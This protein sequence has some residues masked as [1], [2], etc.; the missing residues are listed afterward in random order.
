MSNHYRGLIFD[1]DGVIVDSEALHNDAVAAAVRAFGAELPASLF[2]EFMGSPDEVILEVASQR[3]LEGRVSAATLLEAKQR[4]YLEV[5]AQVRA[6]PGALDFIPAARACF[7]GVA[8][9]TSSLRVNQALVFARFDLARWFD[10]VV[11][12]EDVTHTKPHPEPYLRAVAALGL[13]AAQCVVL[14]DSVNGIRAAREAG[15][16]VIGLTTSFPAEALRAAGAGHVCTSF[17]EIAAVLGVGKE[18]LQ[19]AGGVPI[20]PQA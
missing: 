11:T 3:Y 15:C 4:L 5:Q 19:H 8:L 20:L 18:R 2:D 13:P 17:V 9:A 1:L 16:D 12:A 10:A 7:E 14:E 6:I